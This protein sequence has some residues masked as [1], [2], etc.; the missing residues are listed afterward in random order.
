[1]LLPPAGKHERHSIRSLQANALQ[2]FAGP[3]TGG[4][5]RRKLTAGGNTH[6]L[7]AAVSWLDQSGRM[8][9]AGGNG[10]KEQQ[11]L[12]PLQLT[13]LLKS[14]LLLRHG[15]TSYITPPM[16]SRTSDTKLNTT[17]HF[18]HKPQTLR[19]FPGF[20]GC[21]CFGPDNPALGSP[22]R[23]GL[24][25]PR[26][27]LVPAWEPV[28]WNTKNSAQ[29]LGSSCRQTPALFYCK[30]TKRQMS[31]ELQDRRQMARFAFAVSLC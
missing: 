19:E 28:L 5:W 20:F 4:H 21:C 31:K 11:E 29:S 1:M 30:M 27:E 3:I 18:S 24:S 9:R 17:F 2:V 15:D 22:S 7:G 10:A 8:L 26:K 25:W 6:T 13:V 16:F 23:A 14:P 12:A